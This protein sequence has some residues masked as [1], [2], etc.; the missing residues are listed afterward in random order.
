MTDDIK[1]PTLSQMRAALSHGQHDLIFFEKR[2]TPKVVSRGAKFEAPESYGKQTKRRAAT[3]DEEKV[4]ARGDWLRVDED[5]KKG[6]EP[7]YK[8]T[9][10]PGRE[11]LVQSE[12][13]DD[14]LVHYGVKG[15]VRTQTSPRTL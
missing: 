14:S 6:G 12:D 7:G 8:K 10:M 1:P 9:K 13:S 4:I 15:T 5:G 3:E 11:H 2:S